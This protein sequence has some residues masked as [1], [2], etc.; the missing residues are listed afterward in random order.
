MNTIKIAFIGGSGLYKVDGLS[1]IKWVKVKS[2]LWFT[3][4]R[5]MCWNINGN[6]VAFYQDMVKTIIFHHQRLIIELISRF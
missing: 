1:D 3:I 6:K 4:I 2:S 5:G